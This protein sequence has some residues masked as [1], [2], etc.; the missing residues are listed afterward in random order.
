MRWG[1]AEEHF[2]QSE[3]ANN[4]INMT[5]NHQHCNKRN[6]VKKHYQR[7]GLHFFIFL[8]VKSVFL[9]ETWDLTITRKGFSSRNYN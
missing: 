9:N 1:G 3:I 2:I 4:I 8:F 7:Y 5:F 6:A